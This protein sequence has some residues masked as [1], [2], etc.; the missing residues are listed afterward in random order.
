MILQIYT[1]G[2]SKGNPG[3][4]AIGI[5]YYQNNKEVFKY[6]EDIGVATNNDAEYRAVITALTKLKSKLPDF[7]DIKRIEFYLDSS[8]VVN[9]LNGL[10]KV[11]EARMRDY[12]FKIRI[13]EQEINLPI[14]YA[15]IPREKNT[16][17]D[18]LVNGKI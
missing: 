17:A 3:P 12:I 15:Y 11:K 7:K 14:S 2:G 4:A 13:L 16:V 5:V 6:R 1:D 9:Q 10:F 8:L 18:A